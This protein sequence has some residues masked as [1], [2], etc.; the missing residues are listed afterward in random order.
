MNEPTRPPPDLSAPDKDDSLLG[1]VKNAWNVEFANLHFR[2]LFFT[3]LAS[4]LPDGRAV[5]LRTSLLRGIG[6]R[7]GPGT[8]FLS[9]P[10]IQSQTPGP[11]GPRLNMGAQCLVGARVILEF[12]DT[13]TMGDRVS[14]GDGVVILT[15]THQLGPREHRAGTVVR[16]PV[17]IGSDVEVGSESIILPGAKI[18]DGARVLPGSVVNS[19]VAPGVT[20]GGIPARPVRQG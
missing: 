14:L 11:L 12:G 2:L 18:G 17:A 3:A 15:T 9:M 13:L 5:G 16:N 20:V 4:L 1:R 8:R 6:L 10:K 19:A 7:I